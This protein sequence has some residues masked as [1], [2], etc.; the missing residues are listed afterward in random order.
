MPELPAFANVPI[1]ARVFGDQGHPLGG[2]PVYAGIALAPVAPGMFHELQ[3]RLGSSARLLSADEAAAALAGKID[4][5]A[6]ELRAACLDGLEG[7][8]QA[9]GRLASDAVRIAK[10]P[11]DD[12]LATLEAYSGR[13]SASMAD[14]EGREPPLRARRLP[15]LADL[16]PAAA[17]LVGHPLV[18]E[19]LARL[20]ATRA[21]VQAGR[22][23][24]HEAA[25]RIQAAREKAERIQ[26]DTLDG[27]KARLAAAQRRPDQTRH[28]AR[29][30]DQFAALAAELA[31][32]ADGGAIQETTR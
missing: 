19:A 14:N 13:V 27:L 6:E 30:A 15:G 17:P 25:T 31:A 16:D 2:V 3:A 11:G 20:A 5:A 22:D 12:A 18:L 23:A 26:N 4:E 28:L 24:L 32:L 29:L 10:A 1:L 7:D 8:V 21:R 9:A